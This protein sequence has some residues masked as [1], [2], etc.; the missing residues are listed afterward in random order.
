MT[1]KTFNCQIKNTKLCI[2]IAIK[3]EDQNSFY[4]TLKYLKDFFNFNPEI[5]NI[6]FSQSL[7][8]AIKLKS[9]FDKNI[10][11]I[12]CFF[13]YS[14]SIVSKMK[15]LKIINQNLSKK[16]FTILLNI[17]ILSFLKPELFKKYIDFLEDNLN[18]EKEINLF[19]YFKN[20]WLNKKGFEFINYFDYI[21]PENNYNLK[22]LFFTNNIIESFHD[23]LNKYIPKG[24]TSSKGFLLSI[25]NILEDSEMGERSSTCEN[26]VITQIFV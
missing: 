11:V 23:E 1:I 26:C 4:Y 12:S 13:H 14:Q 8:N 21:K 10:K 17:Q 19:K 16:G 18:E 20:Y 25:K 3:Y 5:I 2:L 6:D 24:K 9:L 15:N 7:Y 22:Y